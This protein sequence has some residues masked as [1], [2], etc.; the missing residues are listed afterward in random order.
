MQVNSSIT[1][2]HVQFSA[3]QRDA[4]RKSALYKQHHQETEEEKKVPS[5]CDRWKEETEI[6]LFS[7]EEGLTPWVMFFG[8]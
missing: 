2:L 3:C 7:M 8:M 1:G 4:R 6:Q 5:S